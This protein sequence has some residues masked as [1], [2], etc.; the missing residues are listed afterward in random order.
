[1]RPAALRAAPT[2]LLA[3][4]SARA[5]PDLAAPPDLGDGLAVSSPAAAG[6]DPAPLAG[7]AAA[8]AGADFPKTTSVLALHRGKLVYEGY[9]GGKGPD[10]LRNT[11]SATK[12][13][14]SLAVGAA[15][16]DGKIASVSEP[17]LGRFPEAARRPPDPL[18]AGITVEDLLTMSS[19]LDCNDDVEESP[20]NEERMYP[21]RAWLPWVLALPTKRDWR[22]DA[23]GRGPFSYCTAGAFL[24]GQILQR[25]TGE[26]VDRY[27]ERRLFAPLGIARAEWPRSPSGEVQTGG[28]LELRSRDLA[29]LAAMVADGGR[30]RGKQVV[31]EAWLRRAL[32]VHRHAFGDQDYGYLF[33]RRDYASRCGKTSGWYMAGNGGNAIVVLADLGAVVVVT[34]ESYNTRG[35]HQQTTRLIEEHVLPAFPCAAR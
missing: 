32:S 20:G 4:S 1:M 33:W 31:P 16:A 15:V 6:L 3:L 24:L 23:S 14:T 13:V 19:A 12:S 26:A 10:A 29:K 27:V 11:R 30:W 8:V 2:L 34:R 22:R 5:A 7:I 25:A 9:F 17:A 18:A 21:Q 28:G 35:M